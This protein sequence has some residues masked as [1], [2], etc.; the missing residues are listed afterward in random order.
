MEEKKAKQQRLVQCKLTKNENNNLKVNFVDKN[1]QPLW[2]NAVLE[3]V[4]STLCSFYAAEKLDIIAKKMKLKVQPKVA[5]TISRQVSV[6]AASLIDQIKT[7]IE[8]LKVENNIE[9]IGLTSDMWKDNFSRSFMNL[10]IHF[11]SPKFI[12]FKLNPICAY[13]GLESHTGK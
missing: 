3:F 2:D 13:F 8:S 11:I 10:S 5:T 4:S 1:L 9:V 12:M 7:I 6:R